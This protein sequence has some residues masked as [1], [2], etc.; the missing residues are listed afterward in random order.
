MCLFLCLNTTHFY[1]GHGYYNM[2]GG[3]AGN[4]YISKL[5]YKHA[6]PIIFID[7]TYP[8]NIQQLSGMCFSYE[9]NDKHKQNHYYSVSMC[10]VGSQKK[11]S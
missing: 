6:T 7:I 5:W 4:D 8:I 1:Y 9:L 3:G 10:E 2:E 11:H